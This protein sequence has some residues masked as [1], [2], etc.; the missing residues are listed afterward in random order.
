[1][2][3]VVRGLAIAAARLVDP[4]TLQKMGAEKMGASS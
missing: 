2:I 3:K 1:M 4:E